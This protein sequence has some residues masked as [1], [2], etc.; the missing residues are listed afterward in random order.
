[1][2]KHKKKVKNN[3]KSIDHALD[4]TF[5]IAVLGAKGVGKTQFIERCFSGDLTNILTNSFIIKASPGDEKSPNLLKLNLQNQ[6]NFGKTQTVTLA[7]KECNDDLNANSVKSVQGFM[8]MYAIND[9][10]SFEKAK[11]LIETIPKLCNKDTP[12]IPI[13]LLAN[14]IDLEVNRQVSS[15]EAQE[16]VKSKNMIGFTGVSLLTN[17]DVLEALLILICQIE[18]KIY[19]LHDLFVM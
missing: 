14:K 6:L 15:S 7:I 4:F 5:S 8:I 16:Y 10:S 9:L 11:T 2:K 3:V 12:D 19:K 13:V 1:M 17:L 18:H